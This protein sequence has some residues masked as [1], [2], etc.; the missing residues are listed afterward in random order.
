MQASLFKPSRS[1]Y[2]YLHLKLAGEPVRRFS[3]KVREKQVAEQ[4]KA[5]YVKEYN[6]ER[7]GMLPAKPLREAAA[8]SLGHHLENFLAARGGDGKDPDYLR[9][10][11]LRLTKLFKECGWKFLKDITADSFRTWRNKQD[12]TAKTLNHYLASLNTVLNW[13]EQDG[14]I[15]G[16]PLKTVRRT[17]KEGGKKRPRRG[18]S[19]NEIRAMLAAAPTD[20]YRLIIRF[21]VLTGLRRDE[22]ALL[23]WGDLHL[24]GIRPHILLRSS[25]VKNRKGKPHPVHQAL[26]Q[27]L[28][29]FKPECA[30]ASD[31]VFP[32]MPTMD[33]HRAL[34]KA[35]GI[36][37]VDDLGRYADFHSFRKSHGTHLY[38]AGVSQRTATEQMRLSSPKL[39]DDVYTDTN[40]LPTAEA[41]AKL[42]GYGEYA[43]K[44]DKILVQTSS[45]QSV[46]VPEMDLSGPTQPFE[47]ESSSPLE[48]HPVPMSQEMEE[49]C[50]AR[51][52][53]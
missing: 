20:A 35:A 2:W 22:I 21:A 7:A 30:T 12:K 50:R 52:R 51:T 14:K 4:L 1:P 25:T 42:D 6:Q 41:V 3:L 45:D 24:D 46:P 5:K 31:L 37:Y 43:K 15:T 26:I 27:D 18:Y 10:T 11:R 47:H 28:A 19:E 17:K 23:Q 8:Q 38:L 49:S 16:N 13:L 34:L 44:H 48:S 32:D 53:T 36:P 39:L 33:Q 40:L 9:I 29:A